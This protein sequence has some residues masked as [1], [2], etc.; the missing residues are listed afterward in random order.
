MFQSDSNATDTES[1]SS[2]AL[3]TGAIL[4]VAISDYQ[5]AFVQITGTFSGTLTFQGSNDGSP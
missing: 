3:N 4:S 5:C 1:G 2:S